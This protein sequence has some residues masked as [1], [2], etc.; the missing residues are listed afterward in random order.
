MANFDINNVIKYAKTNDDKLTAYLYQMLCKCDETSDYSQAAVE[1]VKI[2]NKCG[3]NIP[4]NISKAYMMKEEMKI[5][6]ALRNRSY[7]CLTKLP[8]I[9]DPIFCVFMQVI[10]VSAFSDVNL[11]KVVARKAIQCAIKRGIGRNFPTVMAFF[12]ASM[13]MQGNVK[14]ANELGNVAVALSKRFPDDAEIYGFTQGMAYAT[15]LPLLQ[16]F[17]SG[18]EPLLRS[19]KALKL[20]GGDADATLGSMLAYFENFMASGVEYGPLVESRLLLV[21]EYARSIDRLG[22]LT[23]FLLHRQFSL[24][25]RTRSN[26]P[27]EFCGTAFHEEEALS[28]MNDSA[29]KMAL[30]DSSSMRVQL[31]F[32][33]GDEECMVQMLTRL[34]DC[35]LRDMVVP[36]LHSRL[37][38]TGLAAFALGKSKCNEA[39]WELGKKV[40]C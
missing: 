39:C 17:H 3:F 13:A 29:R 27:T 34:Q 21:E 8:I 12:A 5:K 26:N 22:F 9:V 19:H 18:L 30:R 10:R 6:L 14:N 37:C 1:G 31:A 40:S 2:L 16:S 32:V 15:V 33:F 20:V 36:R 28:Q 24:N 35:P 25:L 7:S 4:T 23:T 38:F 11:S